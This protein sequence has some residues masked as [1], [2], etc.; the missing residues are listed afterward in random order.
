[1]LHV[2]SKGTSASNGK[3]GRNLLLF[4]DMCHIFAR[5]VTSAGPKIDALFTTMHKCDPYHENWIWL[6]T[7][8]FQFLCIGKR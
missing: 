7:E 4:A 2:V 1:M 8:D 5:Y 6:D 3:Q